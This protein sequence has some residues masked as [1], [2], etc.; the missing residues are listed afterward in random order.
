M[1]YLAYQVSNDSANIH[2]ILL[3]CLQRTLSSNWVNIRSTE[4]IGK[5][6]IIVT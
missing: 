3:S 2:A 5:K 1:D 6:T 4:Q